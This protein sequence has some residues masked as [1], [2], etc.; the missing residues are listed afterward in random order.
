MKL[1]SLLPLLSLAYAA[2]YKNCNGCTVVS[3]EN[4]VNW[5]VENKNWC[6]IN[7]S[8][9]NKNNEANQCPGYPKYPCCE[10]CTVKSEDE[11]GKWGI[12]NGKW[13][14][15]KNSCNTKKESDFC[16]SPIVNNAYLADPAPLV[17][18]NT[19]Y[20]YTTHDE[21]NLENDFYT[22]KN[23]YVLSTKDMKNWT[24]HGQILSLDDIDYAEDR[25]WAPQAVAR[26]GK[27]YLYF[28]VQVKDG[29]MGIG[30][31]VANSPLG[32]FKDAIGKPLIYI[33]DEWIASD[34][35]V[36]IDD[37]GQAYLYFGS[38]G[39]LRYVK[40]NSNMTSYN[41]RTGIVNVNMTVNAFGKGNIRETSFGEGAFIYKKNGVYYMI[42]AGNRYGK[43]NEYI[44]YSTSN[45]PVGPWKY[46]GV[47]MA[48]DDANVSNHA[49]IA[50]FNGKSYL[51]Y[52]TE[53]DNMFH[54]K[55]GVREIKFNNNGSINQV[56]KC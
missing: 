21:D 13:C 19:L 15:I 43:E 26:N 44:G 53:Q 16:K 50:E 10:G 17:V 8:L 1:I 51:F 20:V 33:Q 6:I 35:T 24:N 25:A 12:E 9:C 36:F 14:S 52:H 54:R 34:P 37:D 45:S 42:F 48:E 32:P 28:P 49:G 2:Q 47:L 23:W 4:G 7:D 56:K 27:Y 40:L 11:D 29:G 5:G 46:Q 41:K 30:V 31:A 18:G 39:E 55:V 3:T 22:M 38:Q